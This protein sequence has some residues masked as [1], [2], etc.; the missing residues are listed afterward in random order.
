MINKELLTTYPPHTHT[1]HTHTCRGT[2]S[3]PEDPGW[4]AASH[5]KIIS[6]PD[7]SD[8]GGPWVPKWGTLCRPQ[9]GPTWAL[10]KSW[11]DKSVQCHKHTENLECDGHRMSAEPWEGKQERSPP[12]KCTD[13][14]WHR[15]LNTWPAEIEGHVRAQPKNRLESSWGAAG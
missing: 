13:W 4:G 14:W 12:S 8:A 2:P 9:P 5:Y 1:Q 15:Y 7:D 10:R 11:S 3:G 6:L